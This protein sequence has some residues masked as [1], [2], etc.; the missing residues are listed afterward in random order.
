M[1]N[2]G[3]KVYVRKGLPPEELEKEAQRAR[4]ILQSTIARYLANVES[5][6]EP[7]E[8]SDPPYVAEWRV[9]DG[10]FLDHDETVALHGFM[11]RLRAEGSSDPAAVELYEAITKDY[12]GPSASLLSAGA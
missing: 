8:E 11:K 3:I 12:T 5:R 10:A 1:K 2:C 6:I 7:R 4:T 9:L